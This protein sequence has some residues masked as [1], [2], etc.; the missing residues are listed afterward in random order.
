MNAIPV[1][2]KV[3]RHIVDQLA[4]VRADIRA[5]EEKEA[6]LKDAI[7]VL[8]GGAD[9]LGGEEFIARQKLSTRKGAL[10]QK[11]ME[12]DGIDVAAYRKPDITVY[13]LVVE[14]RVVEEAA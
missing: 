1:S 12:A 13:S 4:D 10:D 6:K 14:R 3:N 5:L 7:S 2:G 8:M 9:S 11:A